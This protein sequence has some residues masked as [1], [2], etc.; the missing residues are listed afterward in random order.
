MKKI[1]FSGG[2]FISFFIISYCFGA[3][4]AITTAGKPLT[5]EEFTGTRDAYLEPTIFPDFYD[6]ESDSY[7]CGQTIK[8]IS[9]QSRWMSMDVSAGAKWAAYRYPYRCTSTDWCDRSSVELSPGV[10][11]YSNCAQ[12]VRSCDGNGFCKDVYK[13]CKEPEEY[14]SNGSPMESDQDLAEGEYQLI[15]GLE[16]TIKPAKGY[17]NITKMLFTWTVRVEGYKRLLMVW[18]FLCR[19]HHGTSYQEFPEGQLKTRLY[20]RSNVV[21]NGLKNNDD[22]DQDGYVPVGLIAE[23]T[24]P[25]AGRDKIGNISDP[26]ITGSY[27]LLPTD[28]ERNKIPSQVDFQ[29]RWY[30][31]TSM[32]IKSPANQRNTVVTVFPVTDQKE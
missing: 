5:V 26:T 12:I 2:F 1:I 16:G 22:I 24:V 8:S 14:N 13:P 27:V 17:R 18:P 20:V 30:N 25:S 10:N 28:F 7:G 29:V 15:P 21:D 4:E 9:L 23:M 32:R 31:E 11:N 6:D 3:D 19:G